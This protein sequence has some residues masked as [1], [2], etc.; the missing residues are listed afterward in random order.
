MVTAGHHMLDPQCRYVSRLRA[1][2]CTSLPPAF[3]TYQAKNE[4]HVQDSGASI[5]QAAQELL[6]R[7]SPQIPF[8]T[9]TTKPDFSQTATNDLSLFVEFKYPRERRQ[10]NKTIT[11]MTSR[12]TIYRDQG[13]CVLFIVY[14]PER[15][16][17]DDEK[18]T[19]DFEKHEGV[20][21]GISR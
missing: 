21:V 19:T 3:Q 9:V 11:E 14:D 12:V 16:I 18:F 10:L 8:A 20:W 13:A 15:T 5:L 1:L 7:E 6:H 2:L 17:T 4:R